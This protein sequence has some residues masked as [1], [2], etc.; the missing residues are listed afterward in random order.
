MIKKSYLLW[1]YV[2]T[3]FVILCSRISSIFLMDAIPDSLVIHVLLLWSLFYLS[4]YKKLMIAPSIIQSAAHAP[5]VCNQYFILVYNPFFFAWVHLR[6][7]TW[8]VKQRP[9]SVMEQSRRDLVDIRVV[10]RTGSFALGYG[11][12]VARLQVHELE[13]SPGFGE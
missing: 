13:C 2:R 5:Q 8:N 9:Q 11:W 10:S 12:S 7:W 3:Y 4:G 6:L 1:W